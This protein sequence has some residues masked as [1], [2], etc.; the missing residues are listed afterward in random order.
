[1]KLVWIFLFLSLSSQTFAAIGCLPGE[2]EDP[3][4]RP[5][6]RQPRCESTTLN[7]FE[8]AS[9]KHSIQNC[10]ECSDNELCAEY[11]NHLGEIIGR[12]CK[13]L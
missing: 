3:I 1:M 5:R 8:S 6:P 7:E 12:E 9:P 2:C 10:S 13:T 4:H 11:S